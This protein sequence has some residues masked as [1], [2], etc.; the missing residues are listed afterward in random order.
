MRRLAR[1]AGAT[2]LWLAAASAA[3]EVPLGADEAAL[4]E[5]HGEALREVSV[6]RVRSLHERLH[7]LERAAPRASGG[8]V[9]TAPAAQPGAGSRAGEAKP[10]PYAGQRR[11]AREVGE[12]DVRSVEYDLFEGRVYRIRWRLAERFER[13]LMAPVVARLRERLG[14]PRYDQTLKAKLG[15]GRADL[16]RTGWE[17][18][19]RTLELRQLHPFV[20][21]PLFVTLSD[22]AALRAVVAAGGSALPQPEGAGDWW[23]RP[24]P[25]PRLL[26]PR[27]RDALVAALEARI[28]ELPF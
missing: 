3:A 11:L 27:E 1:C 26:E 14:P 18:E 10:D 19:G 8:A 5:R 4:R 15:S 13:P 17:R 24:Q 28:A 16:R 22:G 20:G 23:R 12:G 7:E 6:E 2:A 25:S 9:A 21:G